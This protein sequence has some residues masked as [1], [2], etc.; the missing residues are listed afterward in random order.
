MFVIVLSE[1]A[2][3]INSPGDECRDDVGDGSVKFFEQFL[4]RAGDRELLR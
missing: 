3:V 4:C 1:T 2:A